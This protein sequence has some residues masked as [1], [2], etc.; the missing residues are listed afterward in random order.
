MIKLDE[1]KQACD[2]KKPLEA[3]LDASDDKKPAKNTDIDTE[4]AE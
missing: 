1:M 2:Q 3:D 4:I